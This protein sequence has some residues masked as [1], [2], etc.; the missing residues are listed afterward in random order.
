[1]LLTVSTVVASG[2][3][4]ADADAVLMLVVAVVRGCGVWSVEFVG[5]SGMWDVRYGYGCV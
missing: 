4:G 3:A 5:P 1:M 2:S